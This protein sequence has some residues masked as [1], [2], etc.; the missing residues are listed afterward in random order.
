VAEAWRNIVATGAT[1]LAVTDNLNFGN[2]TKP[3]VMGQ[4][5]GCIEGVAEAC[6]VLDF[7]VVSG[8][9]SLYNETD[10]ESI[11][12]TPTIGGV[13]LIADVAKA[14]GVGFTRHGADIVLVGDIRGQLGQS[15]YL[16]EIFGLE[17][18][19]PPPVDLEWEHRV[20]LFVKDAI[21][22][23]NVTACHDISDGGLL[24]TLVEM[25]LGNGIGANVDL[26]AS[27]GILFGEDQACYV[28][29]TLQTSTLLAAAAAQGLPARPL[30]VTDG[31]TL[32]IPG[33]AT[34]SLAD[35]RH[36]HE[37]WLPEFMNG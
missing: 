27:A 29:E 35:L 4:I 11:P 15:L 26:P 24:V 23:G 16:R 32:D 7:P 31:A 25:C 14:V 33:L 3:V 5:V 18:G 28:V 34:I 22:S 12:P 17:E 37:P 2:P 9:V 10:G 13:G 20:G 8:N 30:G 6:R 19:A 1:P 21:L 36:A